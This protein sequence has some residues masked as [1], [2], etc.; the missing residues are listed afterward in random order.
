MTRG[1][2]PKRGDS[3]DELRGDAKFVLTV[4]TVQAGRGE[5]EQGS[6]GYIG[7]D[8]VEDDAASDFDPSSVPAPVILDRV[9]ELVSRLCQQMLRDERVL[10]IDIGREARVSGA[11]PSILRSE[12]ELSRLRVLV[13]AAATVGSV[14]YPISVWAIP[15]ERETETEEL[16]EAFRD[17]PANQELLAEIYRRQTVRAS[18]F[19]SSLSLSVPPLLLERAEEWLRHAT[20]AL[21]IPVTWED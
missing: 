16:V 10:R 3:D 14:L 11:W 19:A 9:P 17:D 7:V 15:A 6:V 13:D 8:L 21:A 1:R 5:P 18:L 20:R 4:S 12:G 2:A